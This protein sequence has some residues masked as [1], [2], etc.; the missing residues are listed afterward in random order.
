MSKKFKT[1]VNFSLSRTEREGNSVNFQSL[2]REDP[3]KPIL[4]DNGDFFIEQGSL[5]GGQGNILA[6]AL[7]GEDDT[8]LDK[9]FLN[10][11]IQGS[12]FE[13][14]LIVKSTFGGDFLYNTRQRFDP[15]TTPG[16]IIDNRGARAR[17][18]TSLNTEFLN[19]N[20]INYIQTFGDHSLNV[21]VGSSIQTQF[22][23][24]FDVDAQ[25][26]AS[27]GVGINDIG[28]APVLTLGVGSNFTET[29]LLGFFGRASYIY[30]DRYVLNASIRRDGSSRLGINER[31]ENFPSASFAWKIKQES[32][33]QNVDA[34]SDLKLRLN[35]GK[36]G[37]SGAPPFTTLAR[38]GTRDNTIVVDGVIVPGVFQQDLAKPNLGWETTDQYD[39]G[40]EF[41]LFNSR[42]SGEIDVYYKETT[43]LL[44]NETRPSFTGFN[45][46]LTNIG[47]VQ[48]KGIDVT[49]NATIVRTENFQFDASLN[50]STNENEVV[51]LG[52]SPFLQT[53]NLPGPANDT[54]AQLIPGEPVGVF[55][56][57]NYLGFDPVTGDAIFEDISGP[58]GVP[59]GVFTEEFD[60]QIIGDSNPDF[61]GGFQTNFRYKWV[62]LSAFFAYSVGNDVYNE[63]IFR[64]NETTV[65]SFDSLSDE[66]F[67]PANAANATLPALG[68]N[69]YDLSSSLYVQDGSYLRL[70]TLQLGFNIPGDV[71]KQFD[72]L[73]VYVTAS[74]VFLINDSDYVGFDPDVS[75]DG[76][77]NG[78]ARGFDNIS[79]PQNRSVLVGLDVTF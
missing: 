27:D 42:F 59:D 5:T 45:P 21:L 56:G 7:L 37:N 31:Y 4:D 53:S 51:D 13:N 11:Y 28:I 26:I 17:L 18:N 44:L 78:L 22:T 71:F 64:I 47:E 43:D 32:F 34:I 77:S 35:Y 50:I 72:K 62:D 48:N 63:E 76:T 58:N 60:D 52:Q 73:R 41:S 69:N 54:N 9:I 57:A 30:K 16:A 33:L 74:N 65:N 67:T 25:D 75:S 6:D 2:I 12:F 36:T 68:G 38:F 10:T 79:Y 14:K 1:G 46:V 70:S 23:E 3:S 20:T 8:T 66:I 61:Y 40:I 39:V 24:G 49:L 19:E 29:N 55:W 15:S